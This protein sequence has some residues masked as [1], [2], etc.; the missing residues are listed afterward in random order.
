MKTAFVFPGQGAQY[1]GMG[2]DLYEGFP[3]VQ[4]LFAAAQD[5][6]DF[7]VQATLF[8][9]SEEDLKR[10]DITQVAVT[11]VNLSAAAV[12]QAHGITPDA[13]AGFSL[14]EYAALA[15]A[16]VLR[17]EDVFPLAKL[18]GEIMAEEAAKLA[19]GDGAPGMAAVIGIGPD[20]VAE[21]LQ[22]RS[23][24][25]PANLNSPK[26]TVISG[27]A[28]GL[29]S[30]QG[31]LKSA[32]ARRV[33]TLKVSGPFH[34]PLM[35]SARERLAE[36][37]NALP[38]ADP[39]IPLFSNVTGQRITSGSEAQR[40][41]MEHITS[42]VRWVDEERSLLQFGITRF[43]ETGPGSVLTGLLQGL[44]K[45]EPQEGIQALPAGT[46]TDIEQVFA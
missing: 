28:T 39:Q 44:L 10:T 30:A 17:L 29:A 8:S 37:V 21:A 41:C 11:L 31:L 4:E 23:D 46:Q 2:Q 7:P 26:Q 38:F 33:I 45:A 5:A 6:V 14:G 20:Q 25:F 27:T 24:V 43:L 19:D 9:G 12:L 35:Q 34:S 22:G 3:A 16:G 1:P 13:V 15:T 18:R 36:H 32:G 42:P 40:L